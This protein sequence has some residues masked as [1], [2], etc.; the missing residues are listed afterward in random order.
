MI[1]ILYGKSETAFTSN[2][3]G[4]LTD[5]I[6]CLVT[7]ERNGIF[8][9]EFQ[10][11]VTGKLY[12]EMV[13]NGGIVSVTHDDAKDRQP[14]DI[15]KYSAPINGIVTFNARHI[16]YRL[17]GIVVKP[18]TAASCALAL[19][20]I[21]TN[22]VSTN[23]FTFWTDKAVTTTFKLETPTSAKALLV[24][25]QGS[26]LDVYGKG[27]YKFDK[28][29]VK[30][31]TNRGTNSGVTIR[32]GKN[33]SDTLVENDSGEYYN[34][35]VPYWK[36]QDGTLV[37]LTGWYVVQTGE[38]LKYCIPVDFSSEFETQPTELELQTKAAAYLA[39]NTPWLPKENV[40]VDF[41]QL[42]NTDEYK[43][44]AVLERVKL[45]D[46]VAIYYPALG[47]TNSSAKVIKVVY[48]TL[49][50]RY[51]SIELGEP[52]QTLA[53]AIIQ[54]YAQAIASISDKASVSFMEEAIQA[55]TDLIA[56]GL[57]G[58]VV[59]NR[60]ADGEPEEILI[61]DT[62]NTSTAVN[63]WRWN[64]NGLAHSHSGY[65]GPFDDIAITQDGK[66]NASMITTG[67]INA[68]LIAAGTITADK[69]NA[70]DINSSKTLTVG[71]LTD[72]AA[73]T[74][75]NSNI[76]IGG[77]NLCTGTATAK[78]LTTVAN[79]NWFT[80]SVYPLSA[81]SAT[82]LSDASN[83]QVTVSFD[84]S[85]TGVDTVFSL[86]V[87]FYSGQGGYTEIVTA[88]VGIP[89]GN[90]TGHA[91]ATKDI[92][93][94]MR[95]YAH[96]SGVLF[97]GSGNANANAVLTVSNLKVEI[98]NKATTWTQAPE[99]VAADI[100]TA[101]ST[102]EGANSQ[103]QLIYI[104]RVSGTTTQS[105]T[106]TWI[107]NTTGNQNT[108]TIKRPVYNSSYPV[109][110]VATQRK[111]VGGTVTCTTPQIDQTTTV[112]DGGHITTGT[113]DAS[114]V[115]VTNINA[116][117]ITSGT[118]SANKIQGGTIDASDVTITNLNAS[119]ITSGTMSANKIQ[120]G[121]LTVGGV[122]D[123]HGKI[124]VV[125]SSGTQIGGLNSN[126]LQING[127][128]GWRPSGFSNTIMG[129][130]GTRIYPYSIVEWVQLPNGNYHAVLNTARSLGGTEA[131][132]YTEHSLNLYSYPLTGSYVS[133]ARL[134][135]DKDQAEL[136][137]DGSGNGA[138][139]LSSSVDVGSQ[140]GGPVTMNSTLDVTQ[141]RCEATLSSAGW[142][143]AI[144]YNAYD[145]SSAQG[146]SG[147]IVTIKIVYTSQVSVQHEISLWM[148]YGKVA[149]LNET[150]HGTTNLVDKIRYTY[151]GAVGYVDIHVTSSSSVQYNVSFDVA[152]RTYAQER[153]VAGTL[154]SVAPAP[155]G[156]TVLTEYSFAENTIGPSIGQYVETITSFSTASGL[157]NYYHAFI[158]IGSNINI[159]PRNV[160]AVF[161]DWG[162]GSNSVTGF[163]VHGNMHLYVSFVNN[164][165]CTVYIT[166][167][168]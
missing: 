152:S 29:E 168:K 50:E 162:E 63:V 35:I 163:T 164:T 125:D 144:V 75:L 52:Q 104:S 139:R 18:Y 167:L 77:R 111:S 26:I 132:P 143:R 137:L 19:N 2:G 55:A 59:I 113:I 78:T 110:F 161:T 80:P 79:Q 21:V 3:L 157:G 43:D 76:A 128:F 7:E 48:D 1:P 81:Y 105:A 96:E 166:Y 25:Q 160:L 89:I 147:E 102:A 70:N 46:T 49:L 154:A 69:L 13:T 27:E 61:M 94:N 97:S 60:N 140:F 71:A 130:V 165:P 74:V 141:R 92:T 133:R 9:C 149:F 107:T 8:E 109:L 142:Y 124:D 131:N 44:V 34:A 23:P 108:W 159:K 87:N 31:Y 136:Q 93:N 10:Y 114:V 95:Q 116:S 156:E 88:K 45:C 12:N 101:Q 62:D 67:V 42:W 38:T 56:G 119:N 85:I 37:T 39:N 6:S 158:N 5:C 151:A 15:Y 66:I 53:Q 153:W 11:P 126:G 129:D 103:E 99:D 134:H 127:R 64:L 86:T 72:A 30:L 54:P 33:L 82:A 148:S 16:S 91:E 150:S 145:S 28:F 100:A 32:Y 122:G 106:T 24:G 17:S 4:R 36:G 121:T 115:N 57:G 120:G 138:I 65:N 98:G 84:Y 155:S 58:H 73:A 83:T 146:T 47:L 40:K 112:I 51:S 14:F 90:S 20:G 118:M 41:V 123:A 68:N 117:N 135:V 22:S